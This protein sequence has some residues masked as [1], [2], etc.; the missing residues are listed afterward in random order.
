M[1]VSLK[2]NKWQSLSAQLFLGRLTLWFGSRSSAASLALCGSGLVLS[3]RHAEVI[4]ESS[5]Q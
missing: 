5:S 2:L 4:N 3:A 1:S